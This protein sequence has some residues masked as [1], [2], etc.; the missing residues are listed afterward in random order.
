MYRHEEPGHQTTLGGTVPAGQ[1]GAFP[2]GPTGGF[3]RPGPALSGPCHSTRSQARLLRASE[4]VWHHSPWREVVAL[5]GRRI[6]ATPRGFVWRAVMRA[7]IMRMSGADYYV[8]GSGTVDFWLWGIVPMVRASGPDISRAARG[9]LVAESFW[10]PSSL[11]PGEH[12][13][14]RGVDDQTAEVIVDVDGD[15]IATRLSV[16]SD[17]RLKSIQTQ[18]WGDQTEDK[19]FALIPFGGDVK[20]ECQFGDYSIPGAMNGGWWYGTDK[21]PDYEFIRATITEA[22]FR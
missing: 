9:R 14:W 11:L 17:G 16:D 4:D 15:P 5:R 6:L 3:A 7:G 1:Y 21:Y 19:R 13:E 12:V 18:R 22:G 8:A 20:E 10:L 2:V